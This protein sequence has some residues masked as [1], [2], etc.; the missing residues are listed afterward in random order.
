MTGHVTGPSGLSLQGSS[1]GPSLFIFHYSHILLQTGP[2]FLHFH[3]VFNALKCAFI[4]TTCVLLKQYMTIHLFIIR[5]PSPC[6]QSVSVRFTLHLQS[7]CS[8]FFGQRKFIC[9]SPQSFSLTLSPSSTPERLHPSFSPLFV[10]KCPAC[11]V[12]F[13]ES[14]YQTPGSQPAKKSAKS[15]N[16]TAAH[17]A[18]QRANKSVKY[19]SY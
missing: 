18:G 11:G 9:T 12:P 5:H 15:P 2:Y 13:V 1:L 6:L 4:T 10:F 14:W 16:T 7:V 8:P 17:V 3:S 19:N